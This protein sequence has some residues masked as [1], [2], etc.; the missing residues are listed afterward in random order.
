MVPM[1][2]MCARMCK[3]LLGGFLLRFVTTVLLQRLIFLHGH[4][5]RKDSVND[6]LLFLFAEEVAFVLSLLRSSG[7][8]AAAA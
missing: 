4:V 2:A 6:T 5:S 3:H 1:Y 7:D 8:P